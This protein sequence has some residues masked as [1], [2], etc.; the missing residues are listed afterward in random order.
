MLQYLVI[1]KLETN[2]V[3]CLYCGN[4]VP[5][6][7]RT[8][9]SCG[10]KLIKRP[11]MITPLST[12]LIVAG[13]FSLFAEL[14]FYTVMPSPPITIAFEVI[15]I[16]IGISLITGKKLGRLVAIGLIVLSIGIL[17]YLI[18]K[19]GSYNPIILIIIGVI[20]LFYLWRPHVVTYYNP[21]KIM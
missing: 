1:I 18:I 11:V 12:F 15:L 19:N 6:N 5:S 9:T 16:L 7:S 3:D 20:L 8:C 10:N 17:G 4:E 21:K 2:M 13:T 14:I